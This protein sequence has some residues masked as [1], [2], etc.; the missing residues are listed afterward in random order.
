MAEKFA[1]ILHDEMVSGQLSMGTG[2]PRLP[3]LNDAAPLPK[4]EKPKINVTIQRIE[5]ASDD[6]DRWAMGFTD[7]VR[8]VGRNPSAA[9]HAIPEAG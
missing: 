6:P 5:V 9:M 7:W 3:F 1:G 4:P 8:N 2:F